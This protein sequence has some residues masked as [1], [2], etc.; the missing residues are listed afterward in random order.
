MLIASVPRY[1]NAVG[2]PQGI[3]TGLLGAWLS[4][5]EACEK[6]TIALQD[7]E[8]GSRSLPRAEKPQRRSATPAVPR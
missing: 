5:P 6:F 1:A 8:V 2:I 4:D 7:V 3:I